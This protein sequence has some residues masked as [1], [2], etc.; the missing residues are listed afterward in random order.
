MLDGGKTW[1]KLSVTSD[2][3]G[4]DAIKSYDELTPLAQAYLKAAPERMVWGTNWPHPG[5]TEKPD[6]AVIFD[7]LSRWAPNA[8]TRHRLLV[9]NAAILYG[10]SKSA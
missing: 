3:S 2:T 6:D 8:A 4:K 10:F 7:M 5:V 9:D 1:I